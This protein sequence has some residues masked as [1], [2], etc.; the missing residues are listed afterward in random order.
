MSRKKKQKEQR[1]LK[2]SRFESYATR[3]ISLFGPQA[4][5]TGWAANRCRLD[6]GRRI[7]IG[8]IVGLELYCGNSLDGRT[9]VYL[10]NRETLEVAGI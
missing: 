6:C 3:Q 1:P 4:Y 8:E 10:S 9:K 7:D 2:Y 5:W